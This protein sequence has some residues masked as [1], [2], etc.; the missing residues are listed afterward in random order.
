V[1]VPVL[2]AWSVAFSE[3]LSA[4]PAVGVKRTF[5]ANA[6][7]PVRV[8][9]QVPVVAT[10]AVA[11]EAVPAAKVTDGAGDEEQP[12][13]LRIVVTGLRVE[14]GLTAVPTGDAGVDTLSTVI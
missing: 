12:P 9:E 5:V 10:V 14:E 6:E 4:P 1:T 11:L 8:E 2:L 13:S 3:M 7:P